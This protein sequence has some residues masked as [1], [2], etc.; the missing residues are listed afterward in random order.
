[1]K[2]ILYYIINFIFPALDRELISYI[3]KD[4]NLII[5]DVGCYRGIFFKK[6]LKQNFHVYFIN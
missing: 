6:I 5:F 1:M 4:K 3:K 2:E